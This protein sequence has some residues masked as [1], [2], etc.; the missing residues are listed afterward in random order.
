MTGTPEVV[1]GGICVCLAL[2]IVCL[3]HS[4]ITESRKGSNTMNMCYLCDLCRKNG[5]SFGGGEIECTSD[6]GAHVTGHV[7]KKLA[8]N[9]GKQDPLEICKHFERKVVDA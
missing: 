1:F 4:L 5:G 3:I 8:I 2:I 7:Q 6:A 9:Y